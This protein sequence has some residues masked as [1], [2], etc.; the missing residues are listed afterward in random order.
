M[1]VEDNNSNWVWSFLSGS[2]SSGVPF[3]CRL[4]SPVIFTL[5]A[6]K[7]IGYS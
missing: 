7:T 1:G 5:Y 4:F 2:F 6:N 3:G